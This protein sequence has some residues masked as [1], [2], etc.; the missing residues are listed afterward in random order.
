[1]EALAHSPRPRTR[2]RPTG[3]PIK[4]TP[5]T[6][7]IFD[8][9]D[10]NRMLPTNYLHAFLGGNLTHPSN[11]LGDLHPEN[12]PPPHFAPFPPPPEGPRRS[13]NPRSRPAAYTQPP[14]RPP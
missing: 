10:R 1:M 5:R 6:L 2:R 9:L 3:K 11:R 13:M 4:L 12:T 14:A 7:D 8:R